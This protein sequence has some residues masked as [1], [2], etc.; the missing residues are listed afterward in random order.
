MKL[1]PAQLVKPFVKS[2]KNDFPDAEAIAG[3]VDR[4][5]M[6][7]V[8]IKTDDQ[9]REFA[10]WL[11]IVS[12]QYST[13][14]E[15]KLYGISKRGNNYTAEAFCRTGVRYLIM[16]R[17]LISTN[18]PNTFTQTSFHSKLFPCIHAADHTF[19]E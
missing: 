14:G 1:I 10:A 15:A 8:P 18:R 5:N 4:Q 13:G 11:G 3:A 9:G 16:A 7:F 17:R 6:R 19:G 2:N 12:R